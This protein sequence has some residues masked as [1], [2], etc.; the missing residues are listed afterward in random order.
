MTGPV[1]LMLVIF[2]P[3]RSKGYAV[4]T[5]YKHG[6]RWVTFRWNAEESDLVDRAQIQRLEEDYGKDSNT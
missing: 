1:N 3:T 2:N 6:E 4:D 5:Q